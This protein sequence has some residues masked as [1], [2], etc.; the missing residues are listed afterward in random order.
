MQYD[1][2]FTT[3]DRQ[4]LIIDNNLHEINIQNSRIIVN[5]MSHSNSGKILSQCN[6]ICTPENNWII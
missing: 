2:T 1:T 3:L 4:L 5:P 6:I